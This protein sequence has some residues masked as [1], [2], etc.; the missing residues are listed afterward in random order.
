MLFSGGAQTARSMRD[1]AK[2]VADLADHYED[3]VYGLNRTAYI[4]L[5]D[6]RINTSG[7]AFSNNGTHWRARLSDVSG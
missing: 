3:A 1:E 5:S 7:P 2:Q 4:H 6:A